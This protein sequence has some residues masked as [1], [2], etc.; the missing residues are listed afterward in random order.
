MLRTSI[1]A[2]LALSVGSPAFA[3]DA[4]R[5]P[6]APSSAWNVNYADDYCRLARTFGTGDDMVYVLFDRFSPDPSFKLVLAGKAM[7]RFNGAED[8]SVRFGPD[9]EA[10]RL[11]FFYGDLGKG[12]PALIFRNRVSFG[13][14]AK[15]GSDADD[16]ADGKMSAGRIAAVT[17]MTLGPPS[18]SMRFALGS[19]RAPFAALDKCITNLLVTW[20]V[21]PAVDA[22]LSRR[23]APTGNPAQ[24]VTSEDYPQMAVRFGQQ[25]MVAFR[26]SIDKNGAATAC[27]IQQSSRPVEFDKLVCQALMRRARFQPALDKDGNAVA[28]YYRSNVIF[29]LGR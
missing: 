2:L 1:S 15:R 3:A 21:D 17:E 7:S 19:M 18:R 28:S 24:W 27:H 23:A 29:Q 25:G 11:A 20:G 13:A 5:T 10:Q 8:V 26:L 9:E 16:I 12:Q 22:T 4:E 6:L 14:P